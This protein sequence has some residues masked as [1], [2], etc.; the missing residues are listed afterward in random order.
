M[1]YLINP[2]GRTGTVCIPSSKSIAHRQLISAALTGEALTLTCYG[3]SKDIMA[4]INC[5]KALGAGIEIVPTDNEAMSSDVS[6][7]GLFG[8]HAKIYSIIFHDVSSLSEQQK[9]LPLPSFLLESRVAPAK[10]KSSNTSPAWESASW[11]TATRVTKGQTPLCI[12]PCCESGS[13]LRFLLP[14]A[15][16]IGAK[17]LFKPEGRL[18]DRPLNELMDCLNE[19]GLNV[20]NVPEGIYC[21]GRLNPAEFSIPGNVSSQ[22]I[23]GLLFALPLLSGES[24]INIT[25]SIESAGYIQL[26]E[27]VLKEYGISFERSGAV[28]TVGGEQHYTA[29]SRTK[30]VKDS[31]TIERDWSNAAFFM[32]MGAL[33]DKGITLVGMDRDSSQGDS[34]ILSVLTGFGANVNITGNQ[35]TVSRGCLKGQTIDA[36]QIPDLVPAI[37]ALAALAEGITVIRGAE[38]LRLKESDR[39]YSTRSMLSALGAD[40]KEENDGLLITGRPTLTGGAV[41]SCND[42]RIAMAATVAAS[43]CTSPVKLIGSECVEKSYPSF[44]DDLEALKPAL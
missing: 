6:A 40:V 11:E 5:L 27:N 16:A 4:T 13:T 39:L 31:N 32:C 36:S 37:S 30:S 7:E 43:G 29:K 20:Q 23:S 44:W 18:A 41:S 28:Y 8:A 33:S 34:A 15:G 1:D 10:R 38:R 19:H 2:G 22:Y 26:T 14:I 17:V 35:I 12:L 3:L 25:G 24:T 9:Q 42:H 21:S